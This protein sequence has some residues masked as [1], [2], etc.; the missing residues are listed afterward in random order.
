MPDFDDE[1]AQDRE[2]LRIAEE[3]LQAIREGR[4]K[5]IPLEDVMRRLGLEPFI[6]LELPEAD[7]LK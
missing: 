1:E 3:R 6:D 2:D 4:E 5:T 7:Q